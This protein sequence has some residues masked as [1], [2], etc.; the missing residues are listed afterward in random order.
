MSDSEAIRWVIALA[1]EA[2]PIRARYDMRRVDGGPFPTY[3]SACGR[4]WLVESGIGRTNAA[5]A[6]MHLHHLS[7]APRHAAWVNVGIAGHRDADIGEARL[8]CQ[9]RE[10]STGRVFYPISVFSAPF[11][12]CLLYT[13]PSPRDLS[14]SRM[15]SSA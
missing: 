10:A 15:P 14:T 6:M 8:V 12:L 13:S 4:H 5:A 2:A 7:A 3:Q 11:E 9:V 1:C